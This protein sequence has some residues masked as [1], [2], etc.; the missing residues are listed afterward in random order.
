[1][2]KGVHIVNFLQETTTKVEV[3]AL[4]QFEMSLHSPENPKKVI[5]LLH[6]LSERGK[7]IFRKLS[8]YLP[9]DALILAPNAP[10]P[11][12][13]RSELG[14]SYGFSWYFYDSSTGQYFLKQ[15]MARSWLAELLK[16]YN[17]SSLPLTI[18]GF[19]QGGYLAPLVGLD[20]P[21]TELVIGLGCEFR[22][23]LIQEKMHFPLVG[24]HGK[25][26][27][28]VS[29]E[30]SLNNFDKVKHLAPWSHWEAIPETKHEINQLIGKKV[31]S[32]LETFNAK[33]SL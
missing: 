25:E 6:G 26:D 11:L 23:T 1:M 22:D 21:N 9:D 14:V 8:P 10:F 33:R 2:L 32:I 7:R 31:A 17:P 4:A 13:R 28:I 5:L 16:L 3:R 29:M 19:S 12:P 24:L 30:S 20:H 27:D 18:I 15:D